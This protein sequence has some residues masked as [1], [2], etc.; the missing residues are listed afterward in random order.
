MIPE[1]Q[2]T[3]L[4]VRYVLGVFVL[5]VVAL[6]VNLGIYPLFLEE[7]RRGLIALE[8][9]FRDNWWV[10]TQTGD[11][12]L[13]KPPLYNWSLI[14]SYKLFGAYSEFATRVVSVM[15]FVGMGIAT[16]LF[17]H[18]RLGFRVAVLSAMGVLTSVDILFYFSTLG[19]IDIFYSLITLLSFFGLYHYGQKGSY[20]KL[21]LTVYGLAA[22]GLLTKGLSSIPFLGISL[23]VYF[24]YTRNFKKLFSWA[25]AGGIALFTLIVCGYF[26][27]YSQYEDPSGWWQ[28]LVGESAGRA[29]LAGLLSHLV[30]FPLENLKNM[31]PVTLLVPLFWSRNI[32]RRIREHKLIALL[33]LLFVANFL[34]YWISA[35]AKS[36]YVYALYPL[37]IIAFSYLYAHCIRKQWHQV[38][39]KV[40]LVICLSIPVVGLAALPFV[41]SLSVVPGRVGITLVLLSFVA[42]LWWLFLRARVRP[43]LILFGLLVMAK[44]AFSLIV[45]VTR[46]ETTGAAEDRTL[47]RKIA[48]ESEGAAL[49]RYGD[50]RMSLTI[51]YYIEA[52]REEVLNQTDRFVP[53]YFFCY[54]E[55][56]PE[57][58]YEILEEFHYHQ[59]PIFLI[60]IE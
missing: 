36:R 33:L 48:A 24:I 5:L 22:L 30:A 3:R 20:G 44:L 10:P 56:L 51:V 52:E 1:G 27:M 47:G 59:R 18:K 31:M 17:A 60:R 4:E 38:Y 7:P 54:T 26:Y 55:D 9:I 34:V 39:W 37:M 49:Y 25:H 58:D 14:L 21:F 23:L 11:I 13:R 8:M 2:F 50:V 41:D 43:Y 40:L 45:P 32:I 57:R 16:F 19:E 15:S 53:G 29:G 46:A 42:L 12:Y 28:T 6:F 35:E